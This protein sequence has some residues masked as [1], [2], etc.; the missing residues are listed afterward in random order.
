MVEGLY[1]LLLDPSKQF[2]VYE[3]G[4]KFVEVTTP[5]MSDRVMKKH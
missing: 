1:V 3:I 5:Q 2:T 4:D